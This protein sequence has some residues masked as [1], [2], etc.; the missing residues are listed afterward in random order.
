MF[1]KLRLKNGTKRIEKKNTPKKS[2]A[3]RKSVQDMIYAPFQ[4]AGHAAMRI[5]SWIRNLDLTSM[6]NLTLLVA[7]IV[8]FSMLII[9]II[10]CGKK[11]IVIVDAPVVAIVAD[12]PQINVTNASA[13][14]ELT[15]TPQ[16]P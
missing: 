14:A 5:W 16:L 2:N 6:I 7:I 8:L 10:G 12:K 1:K 11:Q 13:P 15:P 4:A 3:G 9:D